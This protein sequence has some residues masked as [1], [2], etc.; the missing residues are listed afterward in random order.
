MKLEIFRLPEQLE[1]LS[2]QSLKD[3]EPKNDSEVSV[4]NK[5]TGE[6]TLKKVYRKYLSF[7]VTPEFD[8]TTKKSYMFNNVEKDLPYPLEMLLDYAKSIDTRFNNIYVNW[9]KDGNDYIEPH[10]DC[11]AKMVNDSQI[12][13]INLNEGD[14]NRTFKLQHKNISIDDYQELKLSNNMCILMD[15]KEQENYRHWVDPENT[16]EGRISVTFR[17]IKLTHGRKEVK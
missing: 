8:S 1:W 6:Y 2:Y 17:M 14:Y 4:Y 16:Q 5:E 9:Y 13:I 11:T 3:L 12:L 15:S 7:G 10:S